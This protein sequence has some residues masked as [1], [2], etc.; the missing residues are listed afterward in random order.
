[1]HKVTGET[2]QEM[3]EDDFEAAVECEAEL[4]ASGLLVKQYV[5]EDFA[6]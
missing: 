1:M 6:E 3:F 2:G 5:V 4:E